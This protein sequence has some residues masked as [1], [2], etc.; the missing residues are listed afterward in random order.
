MQAFMIFTCLNR[1]HSIPFRFG[2]LYSFAGF[3]SV[4]FVK[5]FIMLVCTYTYLYNHGHVFFWLLAS[6][7]FAVLTVKQ[8]VNSACL[9]GTK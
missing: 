5:Q 8:L 2:L 9:F 1:F 4:Y 6:F 7:C 3:V